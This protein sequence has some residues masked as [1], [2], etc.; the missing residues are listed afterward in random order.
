[1][2][3][4]S[5]AGEPIAVIKI[6]GSILTKGVSYRRAAKFVRNRRSAT[7]EERL[8]VVVSAQEGMTDSLEHAARKIAGEPDPSSLD[9]LWSTGE[10]RSAALLALHLQALGVSAVALNTHETGLSVPANARGATHVGLNL[11]RMLSALSE[12]PVVVAPGF[13][14]TDPSNAIVSLGRGGT[15]LTAILLAEGLAAR[16]CE[17]IKDVPGYFTSDPHRDP[18]ARPIPFLTFEHALEL[19]RNGCDL[20]QKKALEEAARCGL[21][22]VVRSIK[23][24]GPIT[25]IGIAPLA[26]GAW[27]ESATPA[28]VAS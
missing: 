26:A 28:A 3:E 18:S 8:V 15:D 20:V 1:M 6:G 27:D 13:L 19:A 24:A 4:Y 11:K 21:T 14:A 23:N 22:L 9:L 5:V 25:R 10:V 16:R 17:L 7:P 12:F 2:Q